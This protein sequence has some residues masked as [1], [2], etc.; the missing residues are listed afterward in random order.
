MPRL[1]NQ[2]RK[3]A[4]LREILLEYTNA[5]HPMSMTEII[6]QLAAKGIPA[7]R[8]SIYD[9]LETLRVLG[10]DI[11]TVRNKTTGYYVA[12]RDFE[13]PELKLLVDAVVSSKFI[14]E[15]QS[16]DLIKKL[17]RLAGAYDRPSLNREVF[18]SNRAKTL[19]GDI[20]RTVDCIHEAMEQDKEISFKY[21]RWNEKKEQEF[22][23]NGQKYS[24]SPWSLV[25]DDS[26]YYLVGF[27]NFHG[28]IRHYRVD[29]MLNASVTDA[30]R[31]GREEFKKF[32]ISS[33]STA[34]FGMFGGKM[35]RVTLR[36]AKRLAN[37]MLDRFGRDTVILNDGDTF[38]LTVNI[39][40]S[41]VFLGWV[42]SFG[43]E[44][45][46]ISPKSVA[47]ALQRLRM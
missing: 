27:D 37:V 14:P 7:E 41:P 3:L 8:K 31:K 33:Y 20:F 16:S 19:D 46:I 42:I 17:T 1:S 43:D 35:E 44:V 47:E 2:K 24:V 34:V 10:L 22:G 4:V 5:S 13:L 12:N 28:E 29:K 45:E 9:D 11:K 36:C 38:R 40:P 30:P 32:D 26:N 25:W 23:R 39:I 6:N 21:F 15:K 18:V